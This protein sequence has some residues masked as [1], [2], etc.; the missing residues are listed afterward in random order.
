MLAEHFSVG[1]PPNRT[2][3]FHRI[4]L[5]SVD[6]IVVLRDF[7][8]GSAR[9]PSRLRLAAVAVEPQTAARKATEHRQGDENRG[10][11]GEAAAA[12][13]VEHGHHERAG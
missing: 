13:G 9:K 11:D 1:P 8:R 5:S 6:T 7:P 4:R 3:G 10:R 12:E 2:C